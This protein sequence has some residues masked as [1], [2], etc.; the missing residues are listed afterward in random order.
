MRDLVFLIFLNMV[1]NVVEIWKLDISSGTNFMPIAQ[2]LQYT[3]IY[4][5][6]QRIN[7]I[8]VAKSNDRMVN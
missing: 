5:L 2:Y 6:L 7:Y 1:I 3:Q 4:T 8:H